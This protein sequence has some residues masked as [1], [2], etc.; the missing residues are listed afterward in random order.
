MKIKRMVYT[1]DNG[2]ISTREVIVVSAPR[3]NYLVYDVTKLSEDQVKILLHYLNSIEEYR[4]ETFAE[5]ASVTGIRQNA[6]WRSFKPGG[7][8]WETEDEI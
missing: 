8:E 1:K 4:E 5:L 6:L 2:D 7:I 3:E